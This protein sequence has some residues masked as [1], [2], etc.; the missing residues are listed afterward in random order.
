M[1]KPEATETWQPL[2][3]DL[4]PIDFFFFLNTLLD[5]SI[6]TS[7]LQAFILEK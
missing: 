6:H 4:T 1:G 2:K 5:R 3:H 7:T